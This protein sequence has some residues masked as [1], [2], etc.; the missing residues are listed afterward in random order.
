MCTAIDRYMLSELEATL[1]RNLYIRV[2]DQ[3]RN[4]EHYAE[5]DGKRVSNLKLRHTFF[6]FYWQDYN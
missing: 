3:S 6:P 5:F 2:S 4:K 1:P